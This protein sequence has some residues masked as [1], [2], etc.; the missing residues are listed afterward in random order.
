MKFTRL[1]D[2][3][4]DFF[5]K[6]GYMVV[7]RALTDDMLERVTAACDRI[8]KEKYD[9][10]ESRRASIGDVLPHDD[11]FLSLLTCETTVPFVVQLLS[12]DLRLARPR[13]HRPRYREC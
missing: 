4:R 6:N 9:D 10:K 7:R 3:Q 8:V 11:V 1:E 2:E 12:F 5:D 13:R